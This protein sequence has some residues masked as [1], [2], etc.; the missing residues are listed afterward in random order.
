MPAERQPCDV[1]LEVAVDRPTPT[2]AVL[3]VSG[4]VDSS[5]VDRVRS[6][7]D[8]AVAAGA[9]D[10]VLDLAP[11]AFLGSAGLAMLVEQRTAATTRGGRLR[12]AGPSR[13]VLRPLG[14][15]GLLELFDVRDDAATAVA[16]L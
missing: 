4:D 2:V 16:D 14:L 15:T 3:R 1:V 8:A 9:V 10:V 12:L 11:V 5:T 13:A 7:L 6:A